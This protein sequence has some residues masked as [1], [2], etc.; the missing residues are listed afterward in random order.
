MVALGSAALWLE[1]IDRGFDVASQVIGARLQ[2]MDK[3]Q[4]RRIA[5]SFFVSGDSKAYNHVRLS[6]VDGDEIEMVVRASAEGE[7]RSGRWWLR[8]RWQDA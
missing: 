1:T 7:F 6:P 8:W 2:A 3:L 5:L 4:Q